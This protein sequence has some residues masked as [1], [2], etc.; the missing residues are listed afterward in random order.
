MNTKYNINTVTMKQLKSIERIGKVLAKQ[1]IENR[2]YDN[3][4]DVLKLKGIGQTIFDIIK[5]HFCVCN[6]PNLNCVS[7]DELQ[8]IRGI[9]PKTASKIIEHGPYKSFK[10]LKQVDGV[11]AG[12][13]EKLT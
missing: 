7:I 12:T 13:F 5:L 1:I 6:L 4:D 11:G 2:P 10:D 3:I 8:L 9:G